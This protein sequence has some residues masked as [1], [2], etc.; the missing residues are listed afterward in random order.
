MSTRLK[1]R[2]RP[3]ATE[4]GSFLL[5]AALVGCTVDQ[6]V[7]STNYPEMQTRSQLLTFRQL[8]DAFRMRHRTTSCPCSAYSSKPVGQS[9][10]KVSMEPLLCIGPPS[11]GTQK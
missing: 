3:S 10:P 5:I 1:A 2:G 7:D 6:A 11:T 9:M 8:L 4:L